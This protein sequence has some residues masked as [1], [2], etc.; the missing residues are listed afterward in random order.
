MAHLLIQPLHDQED[1][2]AFRGA[3]FVDPSVRG[4]AALFFTV[5]LFGG[6][7]IFFKSLLPPSLLI[8]HV[9]FFWAAA[10]WATLSS[11]SVALTVIILTVS[12]RIARGAARVQ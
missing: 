2:I 5:A 11:L 4:A 7:V 8:P 10:I 9:H 3:N 1:G 6:Y 12:A